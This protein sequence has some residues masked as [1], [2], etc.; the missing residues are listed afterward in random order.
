MLYDNG[1]GTLSSGNS[2]TGTGSISYKTGEISMK[3][4]PK[5]SEFVVSAKYN[6]AHSG[7]LN[8][9]SASGFNM[10]ELIRGRSVSDKLNTV[11]EIR[12]YN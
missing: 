9:S 2:I 7:G 3:G 1:D 8:S 6:S 12:G 10:I 11:V 4:C 5:N